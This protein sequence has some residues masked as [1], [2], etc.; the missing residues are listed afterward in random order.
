MNNEKNK[1]YMPILAILVPLVL[2]N[3]II[4]TIAV[5]WAIFGPFGG[6]IGFIVVYSFFDKGAIYDL[7]MSILKKKDKNV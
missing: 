3:L 5:P 2:F 6:I 7:L 1:W 4:A